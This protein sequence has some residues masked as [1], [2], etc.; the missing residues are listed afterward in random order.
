MDYF[1]TVVI[2]KLDEIVKNTNSSSWIVN[3]VCVGFG[4]FLTLF[5]Q[6]IG[7]ITCYLVE[8]KKTPASDNGSGTFITIEN[9]V[10]DVV[11][12]ELVIDI[13]NT[14]QRNIGL[15]DIYFELR[16]NK[17]EVIKVPFIN[18]D[19][20]KQCDVGIVYCNLEI[21]N[22]EAN[23]IVRKK[24]Q[25]NIPLKSI[26]SFNDVSESDFIFSAKYGKIRKIELHVNNKKNQ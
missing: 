26:G 25:T 14:F 17:K 2:K 23:K 20:K 9:A 10:P 5:L 12:I 11:H 6:R 21:I 7:K 22:L 8:L 13:Q 16:R 24:L 4:A 3:L 19:E 15:R 1:E 18:K